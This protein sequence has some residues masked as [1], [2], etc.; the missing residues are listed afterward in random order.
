MSSNICKHCVRSVETSDVNFVIKSNTDFQVFVLFLFLIMNVDNID[1]LVTG[2]KII[3]LL[4]L[5]TEFCEHAR[6]RT[7]T[8]TR[9]HACTHSR[10]FCA[11]LDV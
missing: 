4:S 8:L 1:F 6:A 11:H 10:V 7:H 9:E 5:G 2:L 3:R